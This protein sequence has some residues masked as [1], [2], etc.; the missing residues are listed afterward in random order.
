MNN[1]VVRVVHPRVFHEE[2]E[3]WSQDVAVCFDETEKDGEPTEE[4]K[5]AADVRSNLVPIILS[6]QGGNGLIDLT[7]GGETVTT[8]AVSCS[9]LAS[10]TISLAWMG[11]KPL[12]S[13]TAR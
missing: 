7:G 12:L 6:V 3:E 11:L 5:I 8:G 2:T 4:L 13:S 9:A 10:R 1:F